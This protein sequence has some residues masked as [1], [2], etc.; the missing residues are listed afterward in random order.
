[1]RINKLTIC[2]HINYYIKQVSEALAKNR[3]QIISY[4]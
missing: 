2:T 3:N 4:Q 1:M